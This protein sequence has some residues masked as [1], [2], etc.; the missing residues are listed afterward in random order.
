MSYKTRNNFNIPIC[1]PTCDCLNCRKKD[2]KKK[3]TPKEGIPK[4]E[5]SQGI[6]S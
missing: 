6:L 1:L 2:E 3:K 4:K 5:K